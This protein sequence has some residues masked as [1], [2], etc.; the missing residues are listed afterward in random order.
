MLRSILKFPDKLPEVDSH[1][2]MISKTY[3]IQTITPI[4]GGGV[5]AG[6]NDSVTPIRPSSV[7]GHLRFWWRSTKGAKC[8]NVAELRQRE[9]EIWG[10]TDNPS[11][12]ITE[13][14]VISK[15]KSYAC[16]ELEP[17]VSSFL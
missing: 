6:E 7:R 2:D 3:T 10:T 4:F 15:G 17:S 12:V 13:V 14:T 1:P 11:K 5:K 16:A 9:G 8:K